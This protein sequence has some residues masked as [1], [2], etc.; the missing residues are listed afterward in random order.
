MDAFTNDASKIAVPTVTSGAVF[1]QNVSKVN[2]FSNVKGIETGTNIGTCNIEFWPNNYGQENGA[3]VPN[4]T[5]ERYDF[6]D[7]PREGADGYG[8]M[9]IHNH[10]ARQTLFAINHWRDGSRADVGIGNQTSGEPDW[11]FAA[12]AASYRSMRLKVL[13]RLRP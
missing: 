11:T 5:M 4:A 13:V 9:Q 10:A 6:G 2:V 1:Q 12:N 8:S 7:H 3:N